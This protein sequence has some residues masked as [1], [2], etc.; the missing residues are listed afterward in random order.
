MS[1]TKLTDVSGGSQLVWILTALIQLMKG[2]CL[3]VIHSCGKFIIIVSNI[4]EF[5]HIMKVTGFLLL[6]TVFMQLPNKALIFGL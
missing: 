5:R 1:T 2:S 4:L 3:F 6:Y